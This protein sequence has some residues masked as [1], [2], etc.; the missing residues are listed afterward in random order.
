MKNILFLIICI[1]SFSLGFISCS[2]EDISPS[3]AD[4]NLFEPSSEDHS[5]TAELARNFYK[6]TGSYLLF[7][8]TLKKV[9]N[10]MDVYGNPVWKTELVEIEYPVIGDVPSY[11]YTFSY[12]KDFARQTKV[13]DLVK[14]KLAIRLGKS[15][16]YSMLLVNSITTWRNKNGVMEIVP[17]N[18]AAGMIPH[19]TQV[20]GTRCYAIST[21]G[22]EGLTNPNYFT[23]VFSQIVL[24]KLKRL[25]TSK[26]AKFYSY[27]EAYYQIRKTN[28]GYKYG[29]NDSIARSLGFWKDYNYYFFALKSDDLSKFCNAACTYSLSEVKEMMVGFP[30]VIERF[31]IICDIIKA[32]GIKLDD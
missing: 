22:E 21:S 2:N 24:D 29:V 14:E 19:P 9:Q 27:G 15:L 31:Q 4:Q 6:E 20:L 8:D 26:L 18:P 12:I 17:N 30:L 23:N 7:N 1:V 32:M 5:A 25:N 16:P 10:G 11:T 13:A 3:Y 28:L